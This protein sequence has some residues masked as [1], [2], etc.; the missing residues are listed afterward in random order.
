MAVVL[1]SHS[2]DSFLNFA[3]RRYRDSRHRGDVRS[4]F[5]SHAA[6]NVNVL[7]DEPS[8][9]QLRSFV[10]CVRWWFRETTNKEEEEENVQV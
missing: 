9:A 6:A 10:C 8:S 2:V 4:Y 3:K 7:L 1:T 5:S